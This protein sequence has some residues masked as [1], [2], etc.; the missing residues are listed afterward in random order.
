VWATSEIPQL[1]NALSA[2]L[3]QVC[4]LHESDVAGARQAMSIARAIEAELTVT[5]V[6]ANSAARPRRREDLQ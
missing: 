5:D 6:G 1:R 4:D 2:A 3:H